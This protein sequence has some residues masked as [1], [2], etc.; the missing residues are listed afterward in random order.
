MSSAF[1]N[2]SY[3]RLIHNLRKRRVD[4]QT[5]MLIESF[6]TDQITTLRLGMDTSAPFRT[7]TRIPQGS[8][9]SLIL[10]LFYNADLLEIGSRLDLNMCTSGYIND[11]AILVSSRITEENYRRL[12]QV[13]AKCEA[14]A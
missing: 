6:L 14:W 2:V 12:K 7:S 10:Y 5:V 13:H 4:L 11:V 9:L 8:P 1:D 3:P